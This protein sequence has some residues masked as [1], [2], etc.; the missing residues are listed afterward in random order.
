MKRD[1]PVVHPPLAV[2]GLV[3]DLWPHYDLAPPSRGELIQPGGFND[4]Y[5]ISTPEGDYPGLFTSVRG[6]ALEGVFQ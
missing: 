5:L 2:E 4:H 6:G 3:A 1:L